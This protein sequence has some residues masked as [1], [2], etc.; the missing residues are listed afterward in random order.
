MTG[1]KY[2]KSL[3]YRDLDAVYQQC[4]GPGGLKLAEFMAVKMGVQSGGRMLDVGCNRGWQA[5]FM[6][7]EFGL[8]VV[9][10]DPWLD[11]ADGVPMVE[12]LRANA[13]KWGVAS[14]V[15]GI[16]MGVPDT[17]IASASFDH[18]YSTTALEMVRFD[19]GEEGYIECLAEILRVLKPGGILGLAEPM[20]LEVDLP[21]D[22]VP[23]VN[24]EEY[25]WAGC[26]RGL[27]HTVSSVE[28]AGFEIIEA[29]Y[30]P[31]AALWWREFVEHDPYCLANP[32]EDPRIIEVDAGRWVSFGCVIARNPA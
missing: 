20:H 16:R 4:S 18:A 30:A 13:E 32:R 23:L 17:G 2:E 26:F 24:Q 7:A 25:P 10:I 31:D 15:L 1:F 21:P 19:H 12:H 5:C 27:G 28:K 3:K 11:R 14:S 9:G 22:L 29:D 8:S 6:A